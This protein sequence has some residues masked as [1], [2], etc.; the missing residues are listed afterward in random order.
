MNEKAK[1]K[2]F[3]IP[4]I[5]TIFRIVLIP[6]IIWSY[7]LNRQNF[8]LVLIILSAVTDVLDGIIARRFNMVTAVGKALDPVADKLTLLALLILSCHKRKSVAIF[9]LLAVFTL[10]EIIMG[11]EGLIVIKKTGTTYSANGLGKATTVVLYSN[12]I[13]HL[14][15]SNLPESLSLII[16]VTSILFVFASLFVYTRQNL[17]RIKSRE[18]EKII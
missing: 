3:N 8:T 17:Q 15:W 6:F 4:N 7:C 9:C 2:F 1:E 18:D 5:L 14:V 12:I 13:I 16:I 10:K 11:I